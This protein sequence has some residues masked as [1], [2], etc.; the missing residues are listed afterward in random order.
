MSDKKTKLEKDVRLLGV[1][2]R[3]WSDNSDALHWRDA[4][5]G[6]E[7]CELCN[8]YAPRGW[9]QGACDGCPIK[10]ETGEHGCKG[11]PYINA[12]RAWN[13]WH[14]TMVWPNDEWGYAKEEFS[15]QADFMSAWLGSLEAKLQ[16]QLDE[17]KVKK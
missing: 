3:H 17:L 15:E 2:K 7:H 14:N 13:K 8:E 11:T 12:S 1:C 6:S 5:V 16:S 10:W 9:K 4:G